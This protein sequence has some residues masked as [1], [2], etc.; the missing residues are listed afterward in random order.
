MTSSPVRN[1]EIVRAKIGLF[2]CQ[3]G[4]AAYRFWT[5]PDFPQLYREYLFVSHS[6]IRASAPLMQEAERACG[7]P[8][9]A[10]DPV[11]QEFAHYL[12]RHI[13]EETG[14]EQWILD[15]GEALGVERA[16]IL[17]HLPKETVTH[18]VGAQ[19]YWIHHYNPIALAGYIAV[20]EGNPP[21]KE[22]IE[23]VAQRNNLSL[24][25]FSGFLYHAK[26]DPQHRQDLDDLLD[27]LPLTRDH[28]SLI[29]L[30]S[31]HTLRTMT[32]IIRAITGPPD[33]Q[34]PPEGP[35]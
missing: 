8:Q 6:I 34:A 23:Q 18:M 3:L 35:W 32:E 19:Y 4:D 28:L 1:S 33:P 12:R 22:F 29:G 2:G 17:S 10:A 9:H 7:Y 20:M 11:L 24:K 27:A 16:A 14:H 15:D 21:E 13:R 30:S 25:C 31:L 26:L 5:S